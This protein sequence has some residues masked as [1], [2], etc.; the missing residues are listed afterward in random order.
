LSAAFLALFLNH[1]WNRALDAS[2]PPVKAAPIHRWHILVALGVWL[3]MAALLVSSFFSNA[4]GLADSL[5]TFQPWLARAGGASTHIH[6][7]TFYFHRLLFFHVAKGPVWTE[8]LILLLAIAGA[9]AAFRRVRLGSASASFIRFLAI[10]AFLLTAFYSLLA[11][12]TP[13]CLLS[14]WHGAI[15]LA[16]VGA[17]AI[18][19][20]I[21]RLI[22]RLG[23]AAALLLG[24]AHLGWQAWMESA[25]PDFVADRRNPYVYAQASLDALNL[26]SELE[27]LAHVSPQG[28]NLLVQVIAP[29]DDYGP[30]PWYLRSFK[31]VGWWSAIPTDLSAPV[32]VVSP[33]FH[34]EPPATN[35]LHMAG[36]FQL[37]PQVLFELWVQP[38][39]WQT[40]LLQTSTNQSQ[41]L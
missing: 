27:S 24:A 15:L 26:V 32:V 4:A 39:L 13:W 6:P 40:F 34:F 5:K 20:S 2:G 23:L 18:L 9:V 14:F 17:A 37:R 35:S 12:K 31:R 16:G 38:A 30:L 29:D 10:Y 22:P 1:A 41:P 11:Y 21:P 8:A 19:R 25:N 33:A 3:I 36:Y 28:H 7:W